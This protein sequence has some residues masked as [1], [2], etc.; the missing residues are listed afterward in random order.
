VGKIT[1]VGDESI[2]TSDFK[3]HL[4]LGE[5]GLYN[6]EMVSLSIQFLNQ[7]RVYKPISE[8]DVQ[9]RIDDTRNTVDLVFHLSLLRKP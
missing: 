3:R 1:V 2:N 6:P 4:L 5:G 8:S 9:S 7:M